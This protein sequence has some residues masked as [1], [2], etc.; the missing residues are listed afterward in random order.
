MYENVI[1]S[2]TSLK[3]CIIKLISGSFSSFNSS[4]VNKCEIKMEVFALYVECEMS[5]QR[6]R[7]P[8][9]EQNV[10]MGEF[11]CLLQDINI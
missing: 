5:D 8:E 4:K 11:Y 2:S 1:L 10:F 9:T 6:V 7:A 3:K